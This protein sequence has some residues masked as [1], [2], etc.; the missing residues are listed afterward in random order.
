MR[1]K[2]APAIEK[3]H[4]YCYMCKGKVGLKKA[5]CTCIRSFHP[6][7]SP[8]L[9]STLGAKNKKISI[10]VLDNQWTCD[11]CDLKLNDFTFKDEVDIEV[12]AHVP[13]R[14]I[15]NLLYKNMRHDAVNKNIRTIYTALSRFYGKKDKDDDQD[16]DD[17]NNAGDCDGE[18]DFQDDADCDQ[19]IDVPDIWHRKVLKRLEAIGESVVGKSKSVVRN[20]A[21]KLPGRRCMVWG[22]SLT[23]ESGQKGF[24]SGRTDAYMET[25]PA[26]CV[27]CR[28]VGVRIEIKIASTLVFAM[29]QR[30]YPHGD[31]VDI[32]FENG[33][34]ERCRLDKF[35]WR[36]V[37]QSVDRR[38]LNISSL[39]AKD[40][41]KPMVE[42]THQDDFIHF[43][44][45]LKHLTMPPLA[46]V[47]N[48]RSDDISPSTQAALGIAIGLNNHVAN[49]EASVVWPENIDSQSVMC[50]IAFNSMMGSYTSGRQLPLYQYARLFSERLCIWRTVARIADSAPRTS[51][52]INFT[53]RIV[54]FYEIRYKKKWADVTRQRFTLRDNSGIPALEWTYLIRHDPTVQ[55]EMKDPIANSRVMMFNQDSCNVIIEKLVLCGFTFWDFSNRKAR[56]ERIG[57]GADS[58]L[59]IYVRYIWKNFADKLYIG[60]LSE[61]LKPMFRKVGSAA[62]EPHQM[63]FVMLLVKSLGDI[64]GACTVRAINDRMTRTYESTQ[65]PSLFYNFIWTHDKHVSDLCAIITN[66]HVLFTPS[67]PADNGVSIHG[68]FFSHPRWFDA[69]CSAY[70]LDGVA[71]VKWT[72]CAASA[73]VV[74]K[75]VHYISEHLRRNLS[76]S[77]CQQSLRL[78]AFG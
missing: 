7:C 44:S 68:S 20:H 39:F 14:T 24:F 43:C 57:S 50:G 75:M 1:A 31:E 22:C 60:R 38:F 52:E 63:L 59:G 12:Q 64:G 46:S 6:H 53:N 15:V 30:V 67:V 35:K 16:E 28:R 27:G 29:I 54:P 21:P 76:F 74:V 77:A 78:I 45:I 73:A 58:S 34:N 25:W 37:E 36:V 66:G 41:L 8:N 23:V 40:S 33:R 42:H 9:Q 47:T 51:F 2:P 32:L 56:D 10:D 69:I 70:R 72:D 19:V 18:D 3:H 17:D 13:R 71:K 48:V 62:T 11:V 5:C 26:L 65:R 55:C 49:V 4:D 61:Q